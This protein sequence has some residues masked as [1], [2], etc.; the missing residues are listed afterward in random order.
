MSHQAGGAVSNDRAEDGH[1][2]ESPLVEGASETVRKNWRG[3]IPVVVEGD[4]RDFE[5][6]PLPVF[7]FVS[8]QAYLAQALAADVERLQE[9]VVIPQVL[10]HVWFSTADGVPLKWHLPVGALF[11]TH[12]KQDELP[13]RVVVHMTLPGKSGERLLPFPATDVIKKDFFHWFKQGMY[14]RFGSRLPFTEFRDQDDETLWEGVA[15][16]SIDRYQVILSRMKNY[17]PKAVPVR[18]LMV[19][20]TEE[21][22][23]PSK[24]LCKQSSLTLEPDNFECTLEDFIGRELPGLGR[25]VDQG[26]NGV[27]VVCQG[28]VLPPQALLIHLFERLA[29]ADLFL[30]LSITIC[31]N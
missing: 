19:V 2:S 26:E 10:R 8:R 17:A 30:Y 31:A 3:G 24:L 28:V 18:I 1:L 25:L 5:S 6:K 29:H 22:T 13:F 16:G 4:P 15:A 11:D 21:G 7:S 12:H 23:F 27:Q 20:D 9:H 14:L